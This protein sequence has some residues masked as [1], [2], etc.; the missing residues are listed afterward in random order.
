MRKS[1]DSFRYKAIDYRRMVVVFLL[2]AIL[3]YC[4]VTG[5]PFF[6]I[7]ATLPQRMLFGL[8]GLATV[9]WVSRCSKDL[10][11]F[12]PADKPHYTLGNGIEEMYSL[13]VHTCLSKCFPVKF[14]R[15]D[16][17]LFLIVPTYKNPFENNPKAIQKLKTEVIYLKDYI[18]AHEL[19]KRNFLDIV[20]NGINFLFWLL[21]LVSVVAMAFLLF[22]TFTY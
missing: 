4:L 10:Q 16:T 11:L 22:K 18:L 2:L 1:D 12:L 17:R 8:L 13:Q 3:V 19:G 15:I 5:W 6:T 9:Y 21:I 14:L 20:A 7:G